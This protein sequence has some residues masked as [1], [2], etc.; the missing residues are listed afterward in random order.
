MHWFFFCSHSFGPSPIQC[1]EFI[2]GL[3]SFFSLVF[4]LHYKHTIPLS[5]SIQSENA[6]F[7]RIA[8][9]LPHCWWFLFRCVCSLLFFIL[10]MAINK[11]NVSHCFSCLSIPKTHIIIFTFISNEFISSILLGFQSLSYSPLATIFTCRR[12]RKAHE[13]QINCGMFIIYFILFHFHSTLSST[14]IHGVQASVL[15]ALKSSFDSPFFHIDQ[16]F[17]KKNISVIVVVV[18]F[19]SQFDFLL[20]MLLHIFSLCVVHYFAWNQTLIQK[21]NFH[22]HRNRDFK[23]FTSP[24]AS[25]FVS[26]LMG[27]SDQFFCSLHQNFKYENKL[28]CFF[29]SFRICFHWPGNA[30]FFYIL[31]F[32]EYLL[33]VSNFYAQISTFLEANEK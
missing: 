20:F 19:F 22:L 1:L 3:S 12:I 4:Q 5:F 27:N 25:V 10:T 15:I 8:I 30:R 9:S 11:W 7:V 26:L 17:H 16:K 18:T 14:H 6:I 21:K 32:F 29:V 2:I 23:K 13:Y 33:K 31:C 24:F 28:R